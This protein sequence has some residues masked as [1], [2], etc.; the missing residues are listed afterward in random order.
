MKQATI[1]LTT[2]AV[3]LVA[4]TTLSAFARQDPPDSKRPARA[5]PAS[6]RSGEAQ[7]DRT[8]IQA[9][10]WSYPLAT[11]PVTGEKLG[12]KPTEFVVEGRLVRTC[13]GGCKGDV[14]KAPA[15]TLKK[16]DAAV[17]AEQ[18]AA[19]P[20]A[21]CAVTDAKL[22]DKA[23][24]YVH[25][26]RLVRLANEDAVKAFAKDPKAAMAKVDAAYVK[27]Q[28]AAYPLQTCVVTSEKLGSMGAPHD[29]LY[30]TTLVRFCC[31]GCVTDFEKD[32]APYL[33]KIADAK[34]PA[35]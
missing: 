26:T 10:R 22:D 17:V 33:K 9:Q 3:A 30:G 15:A 23:V 12:A 18:K 6:E 7:D 34:K 1:I 29:K 27:A 35:K 13:C 32:P 31:S 28:T 5:A 8:V 2:A 16:I 25:G 19:Y 4:V 24:D 14:I 21:T 20:L 11:C